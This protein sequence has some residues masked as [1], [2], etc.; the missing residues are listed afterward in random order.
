M[1]AKLALW[2]GSCA[3]MGGAGPG[4]CGYT[5]DAVNPSESLAARRPGSGCPSAAPQ[6]AGQ[7]SVATFSPIAV[8]LALGKRALASPTGNIFRPTSLWGQRNGK[9]P[10]GHSV[11]SKG[12]QPQVGGGAEGT[13]GAFPRPPAWPGC[14]M[15]APRGRS[16]RREVPLHWS[17]AACGRGVCGAC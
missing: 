9:C 8:L 4:R 5:G 10:C 16:L 13:C 11:L 7:H 2:N 14:Q 15:N 6:F 1:L 17:V 3:T 12:L